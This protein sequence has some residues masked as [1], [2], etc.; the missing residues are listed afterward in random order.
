[1]ERNQ[2]VLVDEQDQALGEMDKMEAHQK[3]AL[4]RAFSIFILNSN[5][6]MLIHQRANHKYHGG[7]LWTNA[8]CSHPQWGEDILVSAGQRL[9]YEM[10][11]TCALKEVFSFVYNTPVENNLIEHEYDH[12]L[13]G[14]TDQQP[15]PNPDEV[16]DYRWI[17]RGD[18]MQ[19]IA[20]KPD[21]FTYWFRMAL[22]RII[23]QL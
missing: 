6:Q 4:H 23:T 2:V 11:L 5:G 10:G 20:A 1:M 22:P 19:E 15:L 8:C 18:L 14:Y 17:S 3:G 12:V 21:Q 7:G 16:Q 13:V 9:G